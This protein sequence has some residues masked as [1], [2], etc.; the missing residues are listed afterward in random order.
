[1]FLEKKNIGFFIEVCSPFRVISSVFLAIHKCL[2]FRNFVQFLIE[3]ET[4]REDL[5]VDVKKKNNSIFKKEK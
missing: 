5:N 2:S 3:S 1:M 4:C